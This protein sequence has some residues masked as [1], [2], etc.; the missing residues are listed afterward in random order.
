[1]R[2]PERALRLADRYGG[3]AVTSDQLDEALAQSDVVISS[4]SAPHPIVHR[5]QLQHALADRDDS[6]PLLLIDFP[7][8]RDLDPAVAGLTGAELYTI[9]DLRTVVERTLAQRRAELPLA[10]SI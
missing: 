1:G 5:Q 2:G 7:M 9:D 4:T 3:R 6:R 10:D 8:P